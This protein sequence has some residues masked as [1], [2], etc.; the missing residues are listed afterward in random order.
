MST[1]SSKHTTGHL[2][3]QHG[4][5]EQASG[6]VQ[7]V[8]IE[9]AGDVYFTRRPHSLLIS[10]NFQATCRFD[11]EGRF[12]S[13]FLGGA[14]YKRGL[15]NT[16]RVKRRAATGSA[17]PTRDTLSDAHARDLYHTVVSRVRHLYHRG[18]AAIPADL[19]PWLERIAAWDFEHLAAERAT[20]HATYK[21]LGILPPDQYRSVV[22]QATEGCTWNR[23]TFCTL[24]RDRPFRIKPPAEF[25]AHARQVKQFFGRA[26]G[27]RS[28]LFLSDANALVIP[29]RRLLELLRIL[30]EEFPIGTPAPGGDHVLNGIYSFLDI[31]GAE[32]KTHADFCELHDASV[33]R[34][35]IG[36]ETGDDKLFALL[37]KPGSPAACLEV[38]QTIK[39]AGIQVGVILLAGAGG[40]RWAQQHVRHSLD[41]IERM[42]LDRGDIVYLSPLVV[43]GDDDYSR[44]M[45]DSGSRAL[46]ETEMHEQVRLFQ[47]AL[48]AS[49]EPAHARPRVALYHLEEFLY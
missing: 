11:R 6:L 38:V 26:I 37:N 19:H 14:N 15:D 49:G 22:V 3:E 43:T 28:S 13:A 36:L 42:G 44:Q 39:A 30:H 23:C 29:Q 27:L 45:R 1:G 16:F 25:R 2:H 21:P 8:H 40:E 41:L 33:K 10:E 20:F 12:L 35:Y 7:R 32:H 31:F 4:D 34:I 46:S 48:K 5:Q 24:Y 17:L 47:A 9:S 18:R